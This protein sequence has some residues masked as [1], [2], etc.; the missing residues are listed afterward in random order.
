MLQD[1]RYA[2]RGFSKSPGFVL[3]AVGILAVGIGATVAIVSL[4]D[5]LY[6]RELPARDPSRL[7]EI[8][9]TRVSVP[10]EYFNLS[11][12]DYLVY[13]DQSRYF[14]DLAAHYSSA[15]IHI[16][17][18]ENSGEING[19]VVTANYFRVLGIEPALGRFFRP[20]EDRV[21][22]RD[23]VAV[24]AHD[25]WQSRFGSDPG[26]LGRTI[27]LNGAAFT[28]VGVA[29]PAFH[30]VPL[31]GLSTQVWM[32]S[33]LFRIGYRYCDAFQR[34]CNVVKMLGRLKSGASRRAAQSELD[35]IARRLAGTYPEDRGR[36]VFVAAARGVDV[37]YSNDVGRPAP[38][39]LEL[40]ALLLMTACANLAGLLLARGSGRRREI[41]IRVALGASRARIL[42]QLLVESGLL[43]IA[44]G[45]L[46]M[47]VA[48]QA[49][50]V[51]SGLYATDIEGRRVFFSIGLEP[52]VMLS[53]VAISVATGIVFGLAPALDAAR[54]ELAAAARESSGGSPPRS[55]LLDTL[56][57]FQIA[58]ALVLA[59]GAGL[60]L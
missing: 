7:V 41:A 49:N 32:P 47:F 27:R 48:A 56:V 40:A 29:P 11:Y 8:Y 55:R 42:R 50:D 9:Q 59:T 5:T 57:M 18:G 25:L 31:G 4:V 46:G 19:S 10:D 3:V 23:V 16:A 26:V 12:P 20:E 37:E 52:I 35:V 34:G 43:S 38:L 6:L 13:R 24:I 17:D 28:I 36:G 2:L 51:I 14:E 15:P 53:A 60:L 39:L 54:T 33:A 45:A 30:G 21:P 22:G 58:L 44:G 1:V